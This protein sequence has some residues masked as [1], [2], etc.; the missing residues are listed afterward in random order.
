MQVDPLLQKHIEKMG[1]MH[2]ALKADIEKALSELSLDDVLTNPEAEMV[3]FAEEIATAMFKKY[4]TKFIQEGVRFADEI[5]NTKRQIMETV[6]SDH[7]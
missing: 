5:K 1:T 6:L 3:I 4:Q 7:G 2:E